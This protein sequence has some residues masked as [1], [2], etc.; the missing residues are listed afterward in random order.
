MIANLFTV[1]EPEPSS[2]RG[3]LAQLLA[4]PSDAVDVADTDGDQEARRWDSPVL[5]TYRVLPP[6]DLA[7][8]LDIYVED[9]TAGALSEAGLAQ[10]L[11]AR[12]ATSVLYPS[13]DLDLD[14]AYWVAVPDGRVVRC[15]LEAIDSDEDTT[16]RVDAVEAEV[17]DLPS[18]KVEFLPEALEY[19]PIGTPLSDAFLATYP[20]GTTA[21]VEGRVH[22]S[23]RVWERLVRRLESDWSPSGRYREDLFRRDLEARDALA[24]L[25]AEVDDVYADSLRSAVTR[26]DRIFRT[27]TEPVK[28]DEAE[29]W[30]WC[31][32]PRRIPW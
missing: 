25:V 22:Y 32:R 15:R 3:A 18:A 30:W 17:A 11:A 10:G 19:E 9:G 27:S 20:T 2:L 31:R 4:V 16:Y 7:L 28:G 23:L 8:E 12:T 13:L 5:C 21:S 26:L 1:A 29:R 24:C 6:G 14:S